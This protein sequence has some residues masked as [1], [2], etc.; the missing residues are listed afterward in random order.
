MNLLLILMF[1][2]VLEIAAFFGTNWIKR[3]SVNDNKSILKK[4]NGFYGLVGPHVNINNKTSLYDLFTGDGL[5]QGAFFENGHIKYTNHFVDTDKL[6]YERKNGAVSE[7]MFV[8]MLF[9]TLHHMK[10]VPNI[11][12][13]ANTALLNVNDEIYALYER[14]MP[15]LIDI[16]F[17]EKDISTTRKIKLPKLNS[18]SAHS[19]FSKPYIQTLDYHILGKFVNY[20][21]LYENFE[22]KKKITIPTKY[23]PV[24]HDFVAINES[25]L[26]C[27]APIVLHLPSILE[28]NVPVRFDKSKHTY[29]HLSNGSN[30]TTYEAD[31]AFYVFHYADVYENENEIILFGSVYE[32]LDFSKLTIHGKYRKIV[33]H[34]K[35]K[36][37]SMER[38]PVLETMNLDF[39]IRYGSK[40]VLRNIENNQIK[41]LVL[42]E[43]LDV[44]GSIKLNKTICGEPA[45]IE[46]TPLLACFAN[47][48]CQDKS[49]LILINLDTHEIS[50]FPTGQT[51]FSI[52]FH[53]VFF[54]TIYK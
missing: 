42:C 53:S 46:N 34:K 2:Q 22:I 29:F 48:L 30:I 15:Y 1:C 23:L 41:E 40:I 32:N 35:D 37:V 10:L 17:A 31:S 50:E 8:R 47:C 28:N 9:M 7:N 25:V 39:P 26:I 27:D 4:I 3:P 36:T 33:L 14:D 44:V 5:I 21:I 52:G 16:D 19:K 38:S 11:L 24:V 6:K 43:G 20:F 49:Y 12:G 51:R 13:L 45:L 54:P 18:F